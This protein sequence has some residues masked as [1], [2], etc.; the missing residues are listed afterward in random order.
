MIRETAPLGV[1][2]D[3]LITALVKRLDSISETT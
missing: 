2:P 1:D 3:D